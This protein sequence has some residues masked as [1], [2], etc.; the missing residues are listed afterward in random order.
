MWKC[1]WIYR[2]VTDRLDPYQ[3]YQPYQVPTS[4]SLGVVMAL[5][6]LVCWGSWSVTLV[7][8]TGKDRAVGT[9]LWGPWDHGD[10]GNSS[11]LSLLSNLS[12]SVCRWNQV[13]S[14]SSSSV[15]YS[16]LYSLLILLQNPFRKATWPFHYFFSFLILFACHS[17]R[18]WCHFSC[19]ASLEICVLCCCHVMEQA[20]KHLG[21]DSSGA[22]L[23]G[24]LGIFGVLVLLVLLV[25]FTTQ[26]V[27][28]ASFAPCQICQ[29]VL[30]ELHSL[31]F[32]HRFCCWFAW[33]LLGIWW[34]NVRLPHAFPPRDLRQGGRNVEVLSAAIVKPFFQHSIHVAG[35]GHSGECNL[36]SGRSFRCWS[37]ES[38][39]KWYQMSFEN[40]TKWIPHEFQMILLIAHFEALLEPEM[41]AKAMCGGCLVVWP[42]GNHVCQAVENVKAKYAKHMQSL[43]QVISHY[44]VIVSILDDIRC[45]MQHYTI[46]EKLVQ[47]CAR[48]FY[49]SGLCLK[50]HQM[51]SS[52]SAGL[53]PCKHLTLQRQRRGRGLE[54]LGRAWN[55]LRSA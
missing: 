42:L 53:E 15:L 54:G 25:H 37:V 1:F 51:I 28:C 39:K 52:W 34:R 38:W 21:Q 17:C 20:G 31:L 40:D 49:F 32:G 45:H 3:P 35:T 43:Y 29:A 11:E 30:H 26:P 8:A 12:I 9:A 33:W 48:V 27:P 50:I 47:G 5:C 2:F 44:A 7:L 6:A 36:A 18:R 14:L 24:S 10:L 41:F 55:V 23:W 22:V 46:T 13:L 16:T 19:P 4:Y